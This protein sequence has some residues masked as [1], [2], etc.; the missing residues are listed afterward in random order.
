MK[1]RAGAVEAIADALV[2]RDDVGKRARFR[3]VEV[4]DRLARAQQEGREQAAQLVHFLMVEADVGQHRDLGL[5]ERDRA[6][7]FVD[8][9]D[10]QF[11]VADQRAGERRAR[12]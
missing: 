5:V 8:L 12:A 2:G 9:A 6:V 11:G 7:A 3:V 1:S 4:H 10:E